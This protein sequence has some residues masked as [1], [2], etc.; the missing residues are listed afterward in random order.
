MQKRKLGKTNYAD[1]KEKPNNQNQIGIPATAPN[2]IAVVLLKI[3]MIL[4]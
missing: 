1:K 3:N 2:L 4:A